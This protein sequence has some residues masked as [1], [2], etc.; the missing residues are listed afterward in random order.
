MSVIAPMKLQNIFFTTSLY[1]NNNCFDGLLDKTTGFLSNKESE[2]IKSVLSKQEG[3]EIASKSLTY[4]IPFMERNT[5]T[6][7]EEII[8][9]EDFFKKL[10]H[11]ELETLNT[12]IF[13]ELLSSNL[14]G[15][16]KVAD[17]WFFYIK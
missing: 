14:F 3:Y 7:I 1:Y 9:E 2:W 13:E 5:K 12:P 8:K 16:E 6:L 4:F 11:Q 15:G 10:D 17:N